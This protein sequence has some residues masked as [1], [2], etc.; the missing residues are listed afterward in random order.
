MSSRFHTV[1][2]SPLLLGLVLF[3]FGL[4]PVAAGGDPPPSSDGGDGHG[5]GTGDT[6]EEELPE[7][8]PLPLPW[9]T[10]R[11]DENR[12]TTEEIVILRELR[13][14]SEELLAR[15]EA[16]DE[17]ERSIRE[18]ER[19]LAG[20]MAK[21]EAMRASI[22]D[23][24]NE[25]RESVLE[26]IKKEQDARLQAIEAEQAVILDAIAKDQE[27]KEQRVAELAKIVGTMKP[28]QAAGMLAGMDEA[29]AL[30]VLLRLKPK[31]AGKILEK[32]PAKVA[33]KLGDR[34]TVH[35]DPT[36]TNKSGSSG[37]ASRRADT[38][39]P[40]PSRPV[41]ATAGDAA[42]TPSNSGDTKP[43]GTSSPTPTKE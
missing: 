39:A 13:L 16:L 21:V 6:G 2:L 43:A 18:A 30:Q 3:F 17:R 41:P 29:V 28:K 15:S 10:P 27:L 1:W 12:C 34:M 38:L 23:K 25:E 31:D 19:L 36:K 26:T 5:G 9:E 22:L 24:F 40:P 11:E 33:Q 7:E 42:T 14:R 8:R 37:T 32:M 20:R 35:R 4:G